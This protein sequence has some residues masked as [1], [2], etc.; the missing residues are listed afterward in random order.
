M[1][2]RPLILAAMAASAACLVAQAQSPTITG[3]T[4]N[5]T[6][7]IVS[8]A[9]AP[10]ELVNINGSDLGAVTTVNCGSPTGFTTSCGGVSVTVAGKAAGVRNAGAVQVIIEVPVD[11]PA[12]S[13]Q[14]VVTRATGGQNLVSEPF[15]INVVPYA[16]Q[17]LPYSSNGVVFADCFDAKNSQLSG[18]NP[19]APG[20]TVRCLGTGFG[21]TN[22]VVPT[23]TIPPTPLP[24]LV[25]TVTVTVAGKAATVASATLQGPVVG[26]DQVIFVV[27]QGIFGGNQTIF[28]S[29]GGVN[30]RNYEFPVA[31]PSIASV[32]NAASY[33][34]PGL[35]NAGI[36]QGA[37]FVVFGS[38]LGPA[39]IAYAPAAFQTT[40]L[41]N[42]SLSV[43]VGG[44]TV[45]APM[46]YTSAGQLA[47]LLP[48]NTPTGTGTITATYN[49][50]P[51]SPA[52]ITVVANNL[53]IFTISSDGQG[54]GIVSYPDYSLVSAAK[55]T[56]CGG[57]NSY[58]GAANPGDTLILWG[59]GLGPVS[60]NDA[61]G[62]GLGQ[63]MPNVPLTLWLGGVQAPVVYQGR[64]GCC[65][66]ED[67]IVFTV[68]NNVPTGC[69]VPLL[70][71]IGDQIS[72][73]TAM[74]VANGSRNCTPTNAATAS[75]NVEQAVT[76]GSVTIGDIE[77]QKNFNSG[78]TGYEDDASFQFL[79]I[80]A[81][82]GTEPFFTSFSDQLPLGTCRVYNSLNPR[83]D[84]AIG[85]VAALD[86]GS[87]VAIQ[88]PNGSLTMPGGT[89][90]TINEAGT[91]LGPGAYTVTGT[92]GK[93]VG[94]FSATITIPVLPTLVS[95]LNST[96]LTVT[97]SS[98]MTVTWKG[99]DGNVEL[100]LSS[101]TNSANTIG[102]TAQCKADASAGA[103]TIPPY[104]LL[105][106]PAGNFDHFFLG[107]AESDV[108]FAATGLSLGT[109]HTQSVGPGFSGFTL[110]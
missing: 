94:P 103:F 96:N 93:D 7:A 29:V 33:V 76:A 42:T 27:P 63:N 8:N 47:A 54:P 107:S 99:G 28:A 95:P 44:T 68:P 12:G 32:V 2:T 86:G 10:G 75:I 79:K 60:G 67:Q 30:T 104:V 21:A 11:A 3:I 9:I 16:P 19:A 88:G 24:A 4:N 69:A 35:P 51:S 71:Q 23:G 82:P 97:R 73:N 20:D 62:A 45:S 50:Q 39:N 31:G 22:P 26:E 34:T 72:N 25:G 64:S 87:S 53:G 83:N 90:T 59:T 6:P 80:A 106:L 38:G 78:G 15:A 40:T 100:Y 108:P 52:P 18:A 74:P 81:R 91:F 58:C 5:A 46:Y 49:G 110:K 56:Q 84:G 55:A 109:L 85:S 36:A 102:A 41:S 66:G 37:I 48:S 61:S 13:G 101:A 98:G 65:V 57:P 1:R 14:L 70:I 43:T 89:G 77:L 17:L 92:G 105:A